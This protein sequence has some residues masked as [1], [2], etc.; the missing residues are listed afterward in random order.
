MKNLKRLLTFLSVLTV[1]ASPALAH[2]RHWHDASGDEKPKSF[3]HGYSHKMKMIEDGFILF[4]G[5]EIGMGSGALTASLGVNVG[6]KYAGFFAGTALKGQVVNIDRVSY[7]F[8]PA[9]LNICGLSVSVIPETSNSVNDKKLK[10]QSIGFGL[11]GKLSFSHM[12]ESDPNTDSKKEYLV[13]SLGFG[14]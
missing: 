5:G 14:F 2:G 4:P 12:V 13:I 9:T 1:F 10:G 6:Y 8:M 11:G 3:R 7:R